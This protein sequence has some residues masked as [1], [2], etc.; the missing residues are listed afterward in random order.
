MWALEASLALARAR[1]GQDMEHEDKKPRLRHRLWLRLRLRRI[2]RKLR[3]LGVTDEAEQDRLLAEMMAGVARD[4]VAWNNEDDREAD[5]H[6][7]E[8]R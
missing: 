7:A 2:R 5:M 8:D 3:R 1:K 6:G 4:Y